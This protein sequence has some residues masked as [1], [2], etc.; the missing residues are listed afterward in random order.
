MEWENEFKKHLL[1]L[2]QEFDPDATMENL[3]LVGIQF[4]EIDDLTS[5]SIPDL[6]K[7]YAFALMREEYEQARL[8]HD[9]FDRRK[10]KIELNIDEEAKVGILDISFFPETGVEH[11]NVNLKVLKDGLCIDWDKEDL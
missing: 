5:F 7:L 3:H 2:L 10:C 11:I 9:E 8:V 4:P 1:K 6:A